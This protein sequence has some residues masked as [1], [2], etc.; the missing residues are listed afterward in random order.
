[1][2]PVRRDDGEPTAT[3]TKL[4]YGDTGSIALIDS[5]GGDVALGDLIEVV[6]EDR[7]LDVSTDPDVVIVNVNSTTDPTG[8][9]VTLTET[10]G[11]TGVFSASIELAATSDEPSAQ[12]AAAVGDVI[13]GTY[14]DGL[15]ATGG[16]PDPVSDSLV[17]VAE[18][19]DEETNGKH[20]TICHRPPGNPANQRTLTVGA[21]ALDAHLAHGDVEGDCADAPELDET[22]KREQAEERKE[23]RDEAFCERKGDEHPRCRAE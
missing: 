2:A 23:E 10:G 6:V 14:D 4:W 3:A 16:D 21:S 5:N 22:T 20:V 19:T 1:M 18:A 11:S 13:T 7:D 17:V 9:A 15:D 12:L 8:I